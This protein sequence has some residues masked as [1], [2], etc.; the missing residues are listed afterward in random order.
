ML[1]PYDPAHPEVGG[2]TWP[3][4]CKSTDWPVVPALFFTG[5]K[6]ETEGPK[7]VLAM[8]TRMQTPNVPKVFAGRFRLH[9]CS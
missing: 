5:S 6:D 4:Q 7:K 9:R 8:Y 1:H 3:A 2:H